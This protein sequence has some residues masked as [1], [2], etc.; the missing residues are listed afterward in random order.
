[1]ALTVGARTQTS[2]NPSNLL[3]FSTFTIAFDS[4][5]PT[6]GEVLGIDALMTADG[7]DNATIVLVLVRAQATYTFT[8][9][10]TND[11]VIAWDEAQAEVANTTDLSAVTGVR[12]DVVYT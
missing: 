7:V 2:G 12:V 5:Y 8:Y 3:Q 10:Y 6:G 4:S 1:M 9:D 11:T